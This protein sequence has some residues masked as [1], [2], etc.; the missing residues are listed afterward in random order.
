MYGRIEK[1]NKTIETICLDN[2]SKNAI[3]KYVPTYI[4]LK[5]IYRNQNLMT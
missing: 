2:K 1:F 3:N 4:I 5:K